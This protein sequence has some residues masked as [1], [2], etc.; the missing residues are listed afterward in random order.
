[1]GEQVG[2]TMR[3]ATKLSE[4]ELALL[5]SFLER[6]ERSAAEQLDVSRSALVRALAGLPVRRGTLSLIRSAL[7]SAESAS[8]IP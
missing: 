6:G 4:P 1:M 7:R 5:R 8:S 2:S 3:E